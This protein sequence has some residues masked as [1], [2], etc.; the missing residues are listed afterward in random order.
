MTGRNSG[1]L[2]EVSTLFLQEDQ[3]RNLWEN[4]KASLRARIAH[5]RKGASIRDKERGWLRFQPI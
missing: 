4:D 2:R 3:E 5:L 1:W